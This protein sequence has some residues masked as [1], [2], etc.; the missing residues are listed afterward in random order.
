V[1]LGFS[2][3]GTDT[4]SLAPFCTYEPEHSDIVDCMLEIPMRDGLSRFESSNRDTRY[5]IPLIRL[6][7]VRETKVLTNG[8][9]SQMHWAMESVAFHTVRNAL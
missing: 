6:E 9:G 4:G 8:V 1:L 3:F 5:C 7:S 2:E